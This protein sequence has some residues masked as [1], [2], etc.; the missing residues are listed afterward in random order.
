MNDWYHTSGHQNEEWLLGPE[1]NGA[2]P[3]PSAALMNGVGRYPCQ[4]AT[5]QGYFCNPDQQKRPV[6]YVQPGK[7]YR[8]RLVNAAGWTQFNF[9][10]DG[11]TLETI[12]VDGVD[13][14]W[15]PRTNGE[16]VY[17][18]AGQRNSFLLRTRPGVAPGSDFLIRA[19]VRDDTMFRASENINPYQDALFL[20][21]T[22]VLRYMNEETTN[23]PN[24]ESPLILPVKEKFDHNEVYSPNKP[25]N[26]LKFVEEMQ[27]IP[28]DGRP[29][30]SRFDLNV[31][32]NITFRNYDDGIR[33]GSFNN[34]PF[35]LTDG[36]PMLSKF[37]KGQHFPQENY[38]VKVGWGEVVQ[39]VVNNP[40]RG[41]HPIHLHGHH[42]WV[43]GIGKAGSGPYDSTIHQLRHNGVLRD[44]VIVKENSWLVLRFKADN[45]GVWTLHVKIK[46]YPYADL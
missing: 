12:E 13:T 6:F 18:S 8:L 44:T 17:I 29:A 22:G 39:V 35:Q 24:P 19:S 11:H 27:M 21:V 2:P 25:W 28:Y 46:N 31:V 33:R 26:N 30:P 32:L 23:N 41:A 45:V 43:M 1:G 4:Y 10:V 36:E 16:G 42:F 20:E 37:V 34:R 7:T 40:D 38:P 9:T 15:N 14:R 3:F 5:A